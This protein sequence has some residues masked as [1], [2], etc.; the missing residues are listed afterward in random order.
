MTRYIT[1]TQQRVFKECRRRWYLQFYRNLKPRQEQVVSALH[2]GGRVH[3]ALEAHYS[4]GDAITSIIEQYSD[5]ALRELAVAQSAEKEF[6]KEFSLA[7]TMLEGYVEW[8]E[9]TGIDDGLELTGVEHELQHEFIYG[10]DEH[11]TL[12]AKL[13]MVLTR[14]IDGSLVVRDYKTSA[15]FADLERSLLLDEQVKFYL[16]LLALQDPE[17]RQ[18]VIAEWVGLRKVLRTATAKPPFYD[19][20]QLNHG[21]KTL[22]TFWVQLHGTVGRI[23]EASRQL[24]DGWSHQTVAPPT[25]TNQCHWKCQFYV[26]CSLFDDGSDVERHLEDHYEVV[27]HLDG[28]YT[29]LDGDDDA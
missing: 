2:L 7:K 4:G 24:D 22:N 20:W 6:D 19:R 14:I 12:L 1:N 18:L 29:T 16:L 15:N 11:V 10:A 23:I 28:R 9:Q 8:A 17:N 25:P 3:K 13:D 5:P 21:R 26:A 27:F